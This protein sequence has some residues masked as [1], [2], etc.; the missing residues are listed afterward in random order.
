MSGPMADSRRRG[1][2]SPG[3]LLAGLALLAAPFLVA[4]F[5]GEGATFRM[6]AAAMIC[7]EGYTPFVGA[8]LGTWL[9]LGMAVLGARRVAGANGPLTALRNHGARLWILYL[10][11]IT[12]FLLAWATDSSACIRGKAFFW[13]SVFIETFILAILA[14]SYNL[15]FGFSGVLSFGHAAFFGLGAYGVGLLMKHAG[16]DLVPAMVITIVASAVLGLMVS[17]IALRVHG[18]YFAIFTLAMAEI[19]HLLAANRIFVDL[20][21]AEDGFTFAVPDWINAAS[22]RMTFYYLSL[23]LLILTFAVIYRLIYSPSGRVLAA[24]RDNEQRAQMLGFN[25]FTY[26]TLAIVLAGAL[27]TMAGILRGLLNKGA[28]PNVLGVGFTVDPLLMTIIG[29]TGTFDGPIVGAF[30]LRLAEQLLRD[31]VVSLG[32]WQ[33]NIGERWALLL[34]VLFIASVLIFPKGIIG[35]LRFRSKL[36]A[37]REDETM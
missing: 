34:G 32:P 26:K 8:A 3:A 9:L 37:S 1:L 19:L 24:V 30:L 13:Q 17:G 20:T 5:L 2:W 16:M 22:N 10:L 6:A 23:G 11:L 4:G 25:T 31:T 29:G 7:A 12:P 35:S 36:S 33:V 21:G 18:L 28:S 15:M 14:A 27:G